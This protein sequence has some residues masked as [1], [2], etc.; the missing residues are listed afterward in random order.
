MFSYIKKQV[1]NFQNIHLKML[2]VKTELG[3]SLKFQVLNK[4]KLI[5]HVL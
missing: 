2:K 5:S 3:I 4:I 1:V